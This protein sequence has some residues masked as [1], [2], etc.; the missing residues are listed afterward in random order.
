MYPQKNKPSSELGGDSG[1]ERGERG[2]KEKKGEKEKRISIPDSMCHIVM[3][4]HQSTQ[5][6]IQ[7]KPPMPYSKQ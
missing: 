4:A 7:S 6:P 3:S 5:N 2:G 1:K